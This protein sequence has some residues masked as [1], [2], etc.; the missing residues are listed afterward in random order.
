L[1]AFISL[2]LGNPPGKSFYYY[3]THFIDEETEQLNTLLKLK[4]KFQIGAL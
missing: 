2:K 3:Y 1:Q 4:P